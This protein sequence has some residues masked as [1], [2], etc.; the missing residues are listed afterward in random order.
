M[1]KLLLL[2]PL[3]CIFALVK[4]Q[5]FSPTY[6]V[7]N[8]D[9]KYLR[10]EVSAKGML[11]KTFTDEDVKC[12][13][14][15]QIPVKEVLFTGGSGALMNT[16]TGELF[17]RVEGAKYKI[18]GDSTKRMPAVYT[19]DNTGGNYTWPFITPTYFLKDGSLFYMK[20]ELSC[21][22]EMKRKM[23]KDLAEESEKSKPYADFLCGKYYVLALQNDKFLVWKSVKQLKKGK[24]P[25]KMFHG[26]LHA[27]YITVNHNEGY[28]TLHS[29]KETSKVVLD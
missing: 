26:N 16:K 20:K 1:K 22:V 18:I 11:K 24:A 17:I 5:N 19:D 27:E 7:K 21:S 14:S 8:I 12:V 28:F 4:A 29:G 2:L 13:D 25:F 6:S 15:V 10:L 3:L 23:V 9:E